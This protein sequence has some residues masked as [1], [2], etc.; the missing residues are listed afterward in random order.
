[1]GPTPTLGTMV[2]PI[3]ALLTALSAS[4][5]DIFSKH[6]LKNANLN[7]YIITWSLKFF[8]L[9][10]IIPLLI[11]TGI[12]SLGNYFWHALF[13]GGILNTIAALLYM[14]AIKN[15]DLSLTIP[16]TTFT[17]LFLLATSPII[18]HE[19][20]SIYGLIGIILIVIGSYTL[21]IKEKHKGFLAPFKA[22]LRNDG[23]KLMLTVAF[24]WSITSNIDKIGI[25]NSSPIFWVISN[26]I[27]WSILLSI[28]MIIKSKK[29][30][31][32]IPLNLKVL[33]PI[34]VFDGLAAITQMIA[35]NMTLV[36]YVISIKRT[37]SILSVLSGYFIF[38]EKNIKERLLG[39]VI[40]VIGVIF[41]AFS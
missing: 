19:F 32:N 11:F 22:L 41:I 26:M 35:V 4:I 16:M 23:P 5:K 20:P 30:I 14:K 36:A 34:G 31:K 13:I 6:G 18:L 12:P 40:M 10:L 1:V 38:K 9:I 2:W 29:S 3:F 28:I 25:K 37:S 17:P 24:I 39:V 7:E 33:I 27:F 21:N 8:S 15:S